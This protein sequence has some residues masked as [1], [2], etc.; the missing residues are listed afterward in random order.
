[1]LKHRKMMIASFAAAAGLTMALPIHAQTTQPAKPP[2]GLGLTQAQR[3]EIRGL[4][5][6]QRQDSEAVRGKMRAARQQ[7]RAAMRADVPDEAAVRGAAEALAALQ[8]DQAARRARARGQFMS[9]LTPEQQARVK[10]ARA[11]HDRQARRAWR[12]QQQRRR[13]DGWWRGRVE[14]PDSALGR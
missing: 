13:L 10:E 1:M 12:T 4:R 7:L 3:D 11:R 9:V 5:E 6:A 14:A 2:A 8:V